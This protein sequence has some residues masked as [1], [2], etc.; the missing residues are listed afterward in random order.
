MDHKHRGRIQAQGGGFEDSESW[1]QEKPPTVSEGLGFLKRLIAKIPKPEFLKR[2][3]SF[4][5]A[6]S[7]I[8]QAG[9]NGGVDAQVSKTFRMKNSK[10][11]RVD[12]EV[13]KGTAFIQDKPSSDEK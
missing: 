4:E 9:E 1:S 5:K 3:Q 7:F 6:A 8:E 13:I 12:I 10:D 11:V 2:K